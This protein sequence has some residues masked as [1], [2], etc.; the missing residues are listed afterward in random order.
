MGR[1]HPQERHQAGLSVP[2]PIRID[3]GRQLF[4]D[5]FLVES[6]TLQRTFH[7]PA[8][9]PSSP[10]LVPQTPAELNR[11]AMPAAAMPSVM[12]DPADGL[13]KMWYMAGY[14]GGF[15]YAESEDG[16]AWRR[17][18]LDV[19][20]GTNLVLETPPGYIRNNATVW[21]D[22]GASS[23]AERFKM[24]AFFRAGSGSWPRVR[25]QPMPTEEEVAWVF[26][27]PDGI[28]WARRA[29]TGTCGDNTALFPN[30]F[31][32]TWAYSIRTFG[33]ARGRLR[34]YYEHAEFVVGA[35]WKAEDVR[36][37]LA[38]DERDRPDPE[39]GLRPELY[40]VDCA[41]YESLMV[42]LFGIYKGPPN[43]VVSAQ[44]IPKTVDLHTGFSRDGLAW[45]RPD[46]SAFLA[47]SRRPGAWDRGYLQAAGGV[48]LVVGDELRFYF[49]AFS[50][51]SPAQGGGPY[52]GGSTALALLRRDG[53]A[54]MDGPGV[55]MPPITHTGARDP[56]AGAS[57]PG[58]LTTRVVEFSGAHLFVNAR[59]HALA[60][61]VLEPGGAVIAGF[62]A[63]DCVPFGGD[64][65]RQRVA[66]RE[67]GLADLAG[68]PVRF[69]F[70]LD[71]GELYA[72]WVSRGMD[73]ASGGYRAA[74][75]PE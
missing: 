51:V 63:A 9:H 48:C 19:V 40:K 56:S 31:R 23:P 52:A 18:D 38:T 7:R 65:T 29:R 1:H 4:V 59:A 37:W 46:R 47:G 14:D 39:L 42:G 10:V 30:P 64:S 16:I 71:A 53:F 13:F 25:P 22:S 17:P 66:W 49:S 57:A 72:F 15:A 12:W 28:H 24:F 67:R 73:G 70:L 11:G 55:P 58:Q 62:A 74:G 44:G 61:E 21:L 3:G 5:D 20:P 35:G 34:S 2:A 6:A 33:G 54:S 45:D 27:S 60:V 8:V 75:G 50:G 26:T 32:G 36:E 69:R 43:H 68:K 41:P